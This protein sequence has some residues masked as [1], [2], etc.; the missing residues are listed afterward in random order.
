MNWEIQ[1]NILDTDIICNIK[2]IDNKSLEWDFAL[3]SRF[4][5]CALFLS[6]QEEQLEDF[7]ERGER[8]I[9]YHKSLQTYHFLGE[10]DYKQISLF[11]ATIINGKLY[12]GNQKGD[13]IIILNKEVKKINVIIAKKLCGKFQ[14]TRTVRQNIILQC[15]DT[16]K[17]IYYIIDDTPKLL[18]HFCPENGQIIVS[19]SKGQ[20]IIFYEDKLCKKRIG[21]FLCC[22]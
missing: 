4:E 19:I 1:E 21:E 22:R 11:P 6:M 16:M 7:K 9:L 17:E 18:F 3:G 14:W 15:R 13:N 12:I 5:L 8:P 2:N 20:R 10:T